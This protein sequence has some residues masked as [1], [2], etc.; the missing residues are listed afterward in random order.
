MYCAKGG[1]V[2]CDGSSRA[3][4]FLT[5]PGVRCANGAS[6]VAVSAWVSTAAQWD[7]SAG[8]GVGR[9]GAAAR[10]RREEGYNPDPNTTDHSTRR[11][12]KRSH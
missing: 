10:W 3:S 1:A 6:Q 2:W 11:Q 9:D 7:G 12:H 8:A 4:W 5:C